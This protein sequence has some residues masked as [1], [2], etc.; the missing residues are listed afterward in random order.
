MIK[1]NYFS[2]A[3]QVGAIALSI[4]LFCCCKQVGNREKKLS[5]ISLSSPFGD[6]IS[7]SEIKNQKATVLVFLKPDCPLS[8]NYTL[9]L[10]TL[11]NKYN[12]D[13]ILFTGIIPA[14]DVSNE[15]AT[16]YISR[17]K[18]TFP[19]LMDKENETVN[20]FKATCTPEVFVVDESESVL[21][22][23]AIDN[24]AISLGKHRTVITENYLSDAL[25]KIKHNLPV[26]VKETK[27]VGCV[28]EKI[29]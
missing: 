5:D 9:T 25:D 6:K 3:T 8:Q 10:N 19:V 17:Y 12:A 24:W 13:D 21:Y 27:A 22:K 15:E 18:I 20:Y 16:D 2:A 14:H 11:Y 29:N 23:G 1:G 4:I 26:A 28:I 7:F